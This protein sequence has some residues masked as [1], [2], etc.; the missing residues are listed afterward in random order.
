MTKSGDLAVQQSYEIEPHRLANNKAY[1]FK[2]GGLILLFTPSC[3]SQNLSL[4]A[5]LTYRRH[6]R[7]PIGR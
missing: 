6:G 3:L 4:Y 7:G 5:K 1:R 2:V